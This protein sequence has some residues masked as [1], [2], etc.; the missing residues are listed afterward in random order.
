MASCASRFALLG[1]LAAAAGAPAQEPEGGAAPPCVAARVDS[2]VAARWG[3]APDL[4]RLDWGPRAFPA[5][6]GDSTAVRLLGR[7]DDGWFAVWLDTPRRPRIAARVRAGT[8]D[9][10][11]IAARPLAMGAVLVDSDIALTTRVRWGPPEAGR[12]RPAAGWLLHWP[13]APGSPLDPPV[14]TAPPL[15]AAGARVRLYYANQTVS[16]AL[17]GVALQDGRLGQRILVRPDGRSRSL[18]GTVDGPGVVRLAS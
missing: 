13:V 11:A 1:L 10:M 4:V 7:G 18:W 12:A 3:V 2:A 6:L 9:T 8:L 14:A 15:V 17:E 16:L 5:T